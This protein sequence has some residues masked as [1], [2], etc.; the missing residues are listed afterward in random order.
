MCL[1]EKPHTVVSRHQ[2]SHTVTLVIGR[3]TWSPRGFCATDSATS[4]DP[5]RV[6]D[7]LRCLS[8]WDQCWETNRLTKSN[9]YLSSRS[10]LQSVLYSRTRKLR[11]FDAVYM[12][13]L[14]VCTVFAAI[15]SFKLQL[16]LG[17]EKAVAGC[18][19][20]LTDQAAFGMAPCWNLDT[21]HRP[22]SQSQADDHGEQHAYPATQCL[23][24]LPLSMSQ[25]AQICTVC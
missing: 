13:A 11:P 20:P 22:R 25:G 9:V 19:T 1:G 17:H 10:T 18:L 6:L 21:G 12:H 8:S 3:M 14:Y 7:S 5:S 15:L 16:Q 4:R 23:M 24:T 2:A